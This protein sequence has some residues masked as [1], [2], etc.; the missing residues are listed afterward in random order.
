MRYVQIIISACT[1]FF[2]QT[3]TANLI[4]TGAFQLN[5]W[6]RGTSFVVMLGWVGPPKVPKKV[7][8]GNI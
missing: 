8:S 2:E 7:S 6:E 5:L 1:D 4:L 3:L